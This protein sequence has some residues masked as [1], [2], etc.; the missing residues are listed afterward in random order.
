MKEA[1]AKKKSLLYWLL[2]RIPFWLVVCCTALVLLFKWVPVRYTPLML[3][4]SV[5]YRHDPSFH[6]RTAWVPLDQF[7]PA[8]LES[9]IRVE[10]RTFAKHHGFDIPAIRKMWKAHREEGAPI[11]GCST[12]SQQ[13]AKNV[14]TFGSSTLVRKAVEVGWTLLIEWIWGKQR[15]MEVYLNVAE[16][17]KGLYGFE[18]AAQVFYGIPARELD[19][20]QSLAIASCLHNPI[21]LTPLD[22]VDEAERSKRARKKAW[23]EEGRTQ[24]KF[25]SWIYPEK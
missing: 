22:E 16:T 24:G 20:D 3:V 11:H 1:V 23:I 12:L 5:E 2:L 8:L 17:G 7:S 25:P 15:I 6:T 19:V 9:V 18:T 4:R 10:D 14:F 21:R 13:T